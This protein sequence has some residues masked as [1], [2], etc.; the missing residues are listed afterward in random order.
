[1]LDNAIV[2]LFSLL[3]LENGP[4]SPVNNA[5]EFLLTCGRLKENGRLQGIFFV[6]TYDERENHNFALGMRKN[7]YFDVKTA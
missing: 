6:A 2:V 3:N 7:K 5:A 4:L 1:M